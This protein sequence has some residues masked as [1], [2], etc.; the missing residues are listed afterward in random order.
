MTNAYLAPLP[1]FRAFDNNGNPAVNGTLSTFA[2]GTSTPIATYTDNTAATPNTNPITLNFRGECDLWLKPNIAYKLQLN[3]ANG[4][5]LWTIDQIVNSQL[6]TLYGGID[7]GSANAY[8]LNFVASFT[9]YVDGIVIY[10][11]PSHANSGPSTINVNGLG[12]VNIVNQ[13]G[14]ALSQGQ[15]QANQTSV[16]M[17]KGG[18]FLLLATGNVPLSGSFT[19]ALTGCISTPAPVVNFWIV[20]RLCMLRSGITTGTSNSTSMTMTG[21]PA[22]VTPVTGANTVA[23]VLTDNG[24]TIGGWATV[25]AGT[26][27]ITFGFGINNNPTGFTASGLKGLA[28]GWCLSYPLG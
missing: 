5:L 15:L 20:G 8:V 11:I 10:W 14:T 17:F 3:D 19:G 23:C 4:V 25:N 9:A 26:G 27:T 2:A 12:V 13:D 22:A 28:P 18:Q 24:I 16:I 7:T 6:I 21:L 1:K